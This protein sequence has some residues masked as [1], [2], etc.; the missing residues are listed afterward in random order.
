M[1]ATTYDEDEGDLKES[2]KERKLDEWN[3]RKNKVDVQRNILSGDSGFLGFG[4]HQVECA[5]SFEPF[6][7]AFV[8]RVGQWDGLRK[9]TRNISE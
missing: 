9:K 2:K 8:E 6:N 5:T 3:K 4:S 7:L 1:R